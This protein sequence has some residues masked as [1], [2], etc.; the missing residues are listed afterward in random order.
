VGACQRVI[1][2]CSLRLLTVDYRS[3]PI[4]SNPQHNTTHHNTTKRYHFATQ[5]L[6]TPVAWWAHQLPPTLLRAGVAFTLVTEGPLPFLL[7][8]PFAR[9]REVAA[10]LTAGLMLVIALTGNYN[11]FNLLTAALCIPAA[12]PDAAPAIASVTSAASAAAAK[13]SRGGRSG[14][15]SGGSGSV[16]ERL[17]PCGALVD[18]LAAVDAHPIAGNALACA[19][20]VFVAWAARFMFA[21]RGHASDGGGGG[22]AAVEAAVEAGGGLELALSPEEVDAWAAWAVPFAVRWS[23]AAALASGLAYAATQLQPVPAPAPAPAP[24]ATATATT[25]TMTPTKASMATK[26]EAGTAATLRGSG[27]GGGG[28]GGRGAGI[29]R[30][31]AC[32]FRFFHA[33]GVTCAALALLLIS[34]IP[35]SQLHPSLQVAI[36]AICTRSP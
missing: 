11:F 32:V 24:L 31:G 3:L 36:V 35:L 28:G 30:A 21:W 17:G 29:F 18:L 4:R 23:L 25:P 5:C 20:W 14:S 27:R 26:D 16:L 12:A 22:G 1:P 9:V 15:G 7:L 33:A 6:P 34:S 2:R 13:P 19:A 8:A 10:A